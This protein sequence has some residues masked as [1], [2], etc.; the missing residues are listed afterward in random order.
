VRQF[1]HARHNVGRIAKLPLIEGFD[2]SHNKLDV[3]SW[4]QNMREIM[5]APLCVFASG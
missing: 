3:T 2:I 5:M 4:D 1:Q